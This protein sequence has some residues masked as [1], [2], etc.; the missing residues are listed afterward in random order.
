MQPRKPKHGES[1]AEK[2]PK[3][4]QEW[5]PTKNEGLTS[6]DVVSGSHRK[7]WWKCDKGDDHVWETSIKERIKG[8]GCPVCDNKKIVNSNCLATLNLELAKQWHPTKNGKLTPY[9]VGAG[10]HKKV[11]WKCD[12][13]DDHEWQATIIN[14]GGCQICN[15][16]IVVKSNS[17]ATLYPD[18]AKEWH[19]S[20]NGWLTPNMV[21]PGSRNKVWW[22]CSKGHEWSSAVYKRTMGRGC[23]ICSN[24]S[25]DITN[26]LATLNPKLAKEWHPT[27]NGKLTPYDVGAGSGRKVW[28]KCPKGSDHEWKTSIDHR[29]RGRGCPYCNS[30]NSSPELRIFSELKALFPDTQHRA[31]IQ[32]FEVDVYIPSIKIGIEYD[33]E[34][35]HENNEKVDARKNLALDSIILLIRVREG[36]LPL[37]SKYDIPIKRKGL[38]IEVIKT[39][40]RIIISN[41]VTYSDQ[42]YKDMNKY[43]NRTDWI[44]TSYY[45]KLNSEKAHIDFEKS[46]SYLFPDVAKEWHPTKNDPMLPEYFTP[47][48]NKKVWWKCPKGEDHEWEAAIATRTKG[49]GC[50]KCSRSGSGR[51]ASVA[52]NLA[53]L[54]P[55]LAKEWHPT[56]NGNITPYDVTPGSGKTVWWKCAKGED[57]EWEAIIEHR[58]KG[59]GCLICSNRK[60]VK[61]NCLATLKP[62]LVKEWHPTKN[63]ELTPYDVGAGSH[64]KAWWICSEGHEWESRINHRS[65]GVGCPSCSAK[66]GALKRKL[67]IKKSPNQINLF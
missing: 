49:H 40:F 51:R 7:V 6:Y 35:W 45:N 36:N 20:K 33:G 41:K 55:K 21:H 2:N 1:L 44:A 26:C 19:P 60:I 63:G 14:R 43:L 42:S 46:I 12:K 13:G 4:A 64:I 47:G 34:H 37:L 15:N 52:Y 17:F 22:I 50:P 25:I 9:D 10:S 39:I 53:I 65:N 16:R 8:T 57:H 30:K 62:A 3:V 5:H 24:R 11:W 61:S 23:H 58:N 28:W 48:S 56:K 54:N 66:R 67:G 18:I 32:G 38:S 27:K 59:I 29:N 31:I